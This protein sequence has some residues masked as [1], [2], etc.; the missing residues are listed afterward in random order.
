[1]IALI[2]INNTNTSSNDNNS[3]GFHMIHEQS[4]TE[5]LYTVLANIPRGKVVTYG[6]LAQLAGM[7]GRARWVGQV[8]KQLPGDTTLPWFKVINAQG[9]ISFPPGS[10]AAERQA[11]K[12]RDDGVEVSEHLRIDLRQYQLASLS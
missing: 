9:K 10:D 2:N 5:R 11:Q 8:L 7:P 3:N 1:M 4:A 12:L 6:Q